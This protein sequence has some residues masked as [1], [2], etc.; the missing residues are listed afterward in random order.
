MEMTINEIHPFVRC[1]GV[2]YLSQDYCNFFKL[3][4][5]VDC[6]LFY[7]EEGQCE[8]IVNGK[9]MQLHKGSLLLLPSNVEYMWRPKQ[10]SPLQ[11]HYVNF[12]YTQN[13]ADIRTIFRL[14]TIQSIAGTQPLE[15]IRF[16]D[17]QCLNEYLVLGAAENIRMLLHELSGMFISK[18]PYKDEL[19]SALMRVIILRIASLA[20]SRNISVNND[21]SLAAEIVEYIH[22]NYSKPLS[23]ELLGSDFHFHP[24]Y[25]N[26][27]LKQYTGMTLHKF[28]LVCRVNAA[29][30]L[31]SNSNISVSEAAAA[32]GFPDAA[33]FSKCFKEYTGIAPSRYM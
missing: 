9:H 20:E 21:S 3:L 7:I 5:T 29:K 33:H 18:E 30:E 28:I 11:Y 32:V 22:K 27:V 17:V 6:R 24:A 15:E 14:T 10:S 23:N 25:L 19:M 4:R 1:A 26:R 2:G 31:L 12:D 13:H 16:Q 8:I